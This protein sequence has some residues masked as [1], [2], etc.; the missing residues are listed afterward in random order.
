MQFLEKDL[1]QIIYETSIGKLAEKGLYVGSKRIRQLKIGNYGIADI[2]GH[3][4][5]RIFEPMSRMHKGIITVYELKQNV[6]NVNVFL[7][8]LKYIKGIMQ[9]LEKRN[10]YYN[11]NYELVLI[12][13]TVDLNSSFVYMADIFQQELNEVDTDCTSLFSF[14]MFTYNFDIDGI[15]FKQVENYSLTNHGFDKK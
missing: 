3:S 1:E 12:G 13:K 10:L 7:Q 14:S 5:P 6:L 11:Y 2:V 9:Y 4:R 15:S 8:G